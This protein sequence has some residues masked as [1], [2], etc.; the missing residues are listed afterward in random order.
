[1]LR[2]IEDFDRKRPM[3]D[4]FE[5]DATP[6]K[7]LFLS[8]IADYDFETAVC[9]LIDNAIDH[10]TYNGRPKHLKVELFLE[11][12]RQMVVVKDNAGG[13]RRSEIELLVTPGAS[14]EIVDQQLI[15]NFGV[16]GKRAGVAL[17]A[18]TEVTTRAKSDHGLRFVLDD[19][20]LSSPSWNIEVKRLENIETGGTK[21]KI[22]E[23]RQGFDHQDLDRLK[24][25]LSE[26]YAMFLGEECSIFVN[27]EQVNRAIFTNWA[28]P[29]DYSPQTSIFT[30]KPNGTDEVTVRL[31]AGL[32]HDRNPSTENYGVY[33]YCN[34]RLIASHLRTYEVGF[35]KGA[36]GTTH[37]DASLCRVIVELSGPPELMPWTSNKSSIS[38][39]SPT[40][41]E[42]R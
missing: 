8:I 18:R 6:E 37:P 16:G 29:P 7:R 5:I 34:N 12:P 30:I 1:M 28:Y 24:E 42:I 38:W 31:T 35:H 33:F 11:I 2:S 13:V 19:D 22:S 26:T 36:A 9:E 20:W 3:D 32:I 39:S 25:H 27:G 4:Q 17:G 23:L 41:L 40:F 10:W 21:V 14:R 15:G